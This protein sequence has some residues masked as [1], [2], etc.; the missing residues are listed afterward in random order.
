MTEP[1]S[2]HLTRRIP[3]VAA[4]LHLPTSER[5][6][7]LVVHCPFCETDHHHGAIDYTRHDV[8]KITV[9]VA[10]C[11][12]WP[13]SSAAS[14]YVCSGM[15]IRIADISTTA[16]KGDVRKAHPI[17]TKRS[18]RLWQRLEAPDRAAIRAEGRKKSTDAAGFLSDWHGSALRREAVAAIFGRA[19]GWS[20]DHAHL[21][22]RVGLRGWGQWLFDPPDD[23]GHSSGR[24]GKGGNLLSLLAALSGWSIPDLVR[25]ILRHVD[26]SLADA[27]LD[28]ISAIL[29]GWTARG[30][31]RRR[32]DHR[33][34]EPLD[35]W[36]ADPIARR[37]PGFGNYPGIENPTHEI[38]AASVFQGIGHRVARKA[39]LLAVP[40]GGDG[41]RSMGDSSIWCGRWGE[42]STISTDGIETYPHGL[43]AILAKLYGLPRGLVVL[44]LLEAS[45][46]VRLD[47]TA[48]FD[49]ME[50]R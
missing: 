43:T 2:T 7:A 9:E 25:E 23:W 28:R 24:L 20:S 29:S 40:G 44:R 3:S 34:P 17:I 32:V 39:V 26:G 48:A 1:A 33:E 38:K 42:A 37:P 11:Y 10:Y 30:S 27:D 50:V 31:I 41:A 4:T 49:L 46:G 5:S 15:E 21:G 22:L 18:W 19:C 45:T 36:V 12:A 14:P 47:A 6:R 16:P 13:H 35:E 8:G